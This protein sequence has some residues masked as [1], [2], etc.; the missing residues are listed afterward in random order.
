MKRT[1]AGTYAQEV[2]T[3]NPALLGNM[4]LASAVFLLGEGQTVDVVFL[5]PEHSD[6]N[7]MYSIH[8]ERS[9]LFT[10][11][12]NPVY[13]EGYPTEAFN[14]FRGSKLISEASVILEPTIKEPGLQL[15]STQI[16]GGFKDGA[17]GGD[18]R[19][20]LGFVV[21]SLTPYLFRFENK[22]PA[23]SYVSIKFDWIEDVRE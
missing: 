3:T 8:S 22:F 10:K 4:F 23:D 18:F 6:L 21:K 1:A 20:D 2:I 7:L 11:Y 14:R 9:V 19:E 17:T 12:E 13:G 5:A 15:F 16:G